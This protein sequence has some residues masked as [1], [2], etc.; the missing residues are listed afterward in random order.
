METTA[1]EWAQQLFRDNSLR[2]RREDIKR[3]VQLGFGR[4]SPEDIDQDAAWTRLLQGIRL[5]PGRI[6]MARTSMLFMGSRGKPS[7]SWRLPCQR[8]I[9][10]CPTA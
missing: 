1:L 10:R 3:L 7:P 2:T 5:K 9:S 4:V 6:R 8:R